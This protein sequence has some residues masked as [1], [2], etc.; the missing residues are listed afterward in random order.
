MDSRL[1]PLN[2]ADMFGDTLSG[3]LTGGLPDIDMRLK[4]VRL[5]ERERA[6]KL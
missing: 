5:L 1:V 3:M 2:E 6:V 4:L